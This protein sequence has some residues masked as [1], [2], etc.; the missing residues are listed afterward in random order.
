MNPVYL[1]WLAQF[2]IFTVHGATGFIF[3]AEATVGMVAVIGLVV[4]TSIPLFRLALRRGLS[5]PPG[6][7]FYILVLAAAVLLAAVFNN[8]LLGPYATCT[9]KYAT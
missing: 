3:A 7:V 5:N 8:F 2:A 1:L 6:K 9:D 4:A